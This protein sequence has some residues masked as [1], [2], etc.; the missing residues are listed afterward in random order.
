MHGKE[1]NHQLHCDRIPVY[2]LNPLMRVPPVALCKALT[3]LNCLELVRNHAVI[4]DCTDNVYARYLLNDACVLSGK[5][6][7]S[8][9]ALKFDGQVKLSV[10]IF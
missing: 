9:S 6:L 8:A 1:V 4:L 5:A 7:V 2:R 10:F 3:T